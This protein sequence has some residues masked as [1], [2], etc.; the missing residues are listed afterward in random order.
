MWLAPVPAMAAWNQTLD[1]RQVEALR[2]LQEDGQ[3]DIVSELVGLFLTETQSWLA[4]AEAAAPR[5]ETGTLHT[6]AHSLKSS[7]AV[8]GA[9][10]MRAL[11]IQLELE[12]QAGAV[13]CAQGLVDELSREFQTVDAELRRYIAARQG[14]AP[15]GAQ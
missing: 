12:V 1:L 8:M 14:T 13:E 10:R 7:C 11:A 6:V 9:A 15:A 2:S 3:C 5:H 4:A